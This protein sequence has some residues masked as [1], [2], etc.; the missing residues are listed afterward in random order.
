M[1]SF[2]I[3]CL[4]FTEKKENHRANLS[5]PCLLINKKY[6]IYQMSM[7]AFTIQPYKGRLMERG[8]ESPM[9]L[10]VAPFNWNNKENSDTNKRPLNSVP[11][12]NIG[13]M[14]TNRKH[15]KLGRK[16]FNRSLSL[17]ESD[18]DEN[19]LG[20]NQKRKEKSKNK[21]CWWNQVYFPYMIM[22]Y[23]QLFFNLFIVA[24]VI[25]LVI[26]F[27]RTVQRDVDIKV[28]EYL[29][30]IMSEITQCS[31]QYIENRCTPDQRVPAMEKACVQWE[32]CMNRDPA[33]VGRA[34]VSAETFAEII[35][36][37]I[38]PISMKT[39]VFFTII[40]FGFLFLSNYAFGYARSKVANPFKNNNKPVYHHR[41]V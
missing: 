20:P 24:I 29:V 32:N 35:N 12:F 5:F 3:L 41:P 14:P 28:E 33:V 36:S 9:D 39:M 37:F 19:I 22:G 7:K 18:E 26:Q 38:E 17:E 25:Y 15:A 2:T 16:Q 23:L 21:S 40:V 1:T 34:K 4:S 30:E 10:S 8:K 11:V 13:S 27:I 31:K 6:S